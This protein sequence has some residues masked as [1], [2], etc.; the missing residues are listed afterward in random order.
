VWAA[1]YV[2]ERVL[3]FEVPLCVWYPHSQVPT[4]RFLAQ[5]E[6]ADFDPAHPSLHTKG[7]LGLQLSLLKHTVKGTFF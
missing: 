3:G 6:A 5:L 4:Q 7:Y 1:G 2:V